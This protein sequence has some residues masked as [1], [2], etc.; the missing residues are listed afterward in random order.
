DEIA[1]SD[2][3]CIYDADG[4]GGE[5]LVVEIAP[6]VPLDDVAAVCTAGSRT[7]AGTGFVCGLPG[8]GVF[9]ATER[10]G[11]LLTL[12][13]AAVPAATTADRLATALD[14]QLTLVG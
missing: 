11:D 10:D 3:R 12:A 4:G 7:P 8:G 2:T 5:F 6:A 9:A 1:A 14:A 13:A